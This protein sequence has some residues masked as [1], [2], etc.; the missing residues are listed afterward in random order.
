MFMVS[1]FQLHGLS[2]IGGTGTQ[3]WQDNATWDQADFPNDIDSEDE[4]YPVADL[5]VALGADLTVNAGTTPVTI[6][7]LKLGGTS[8]Q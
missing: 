2:V 3:N 8:E 7:G 6:A 5:G 4:I 1:L